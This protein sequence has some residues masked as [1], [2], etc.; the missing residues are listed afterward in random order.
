MG[1]VFVQHVADHTFI[2][3]DRLR[4]GRRCED[5]FG[6]GIDLP[7]RYGRTYA[8]GVVW[9]RVSRSFV[10]HDPGKSNASAYD[11]GESMDAASV[12]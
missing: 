7:F 11:C 9:K 4:R 6:A 3:Q 12:F 1:L 10:I 5:Q 8:M 2:D